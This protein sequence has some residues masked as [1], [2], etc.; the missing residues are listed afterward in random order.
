MR[1]LLKPVRHFGLVYLYYL[2]YLFHLIDCALGTW[3]E[4]DKESDEYSFDLSVITPSTVHVE[5]DV[6]ERLALAQWF[7]KFKG[8]LQQFCP[9]TISKR[10]EG[11]D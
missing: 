1:D 7:R 5:P 8:S 6:K 2:V 4:E 11:E 3:R 9:A 10:A